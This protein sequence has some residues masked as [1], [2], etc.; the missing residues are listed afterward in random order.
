[1]IVLCQ[2]PD[3]IVPTACNDDEMMLLASVGPISCVPGMAIVALFA[4]VIKPLPLIVTIG[5]VADEPKVPI[6]V[7]TVA[8]VAAVVPGPVAVTSPINE[9]I[10]VSV[11][12]V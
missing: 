5:T 12:V 7:F 3:D 9:V 11:Q 10:A 6:L 8:R 1:M 2:I 4:A